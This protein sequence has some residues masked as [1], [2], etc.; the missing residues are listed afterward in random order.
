MCVLMQSGLDGGERLVD[1]GDRVGGLQADLRSSVMVLVQ[2]VALRVG[3]RAAFKLARWPLL[4]KP[5]ASAAPYRTP[6][7]PR[8]RGTFGRRN[9]NAMR[10]YQGLLVTDITAELTPSARASASCLHTGALRR[11]NL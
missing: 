9:N 1:N 8:T 6:P 10:S 5:Q 4:M 7:C 11:L 3:A 2:A